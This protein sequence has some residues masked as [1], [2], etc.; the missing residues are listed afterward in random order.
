MPSVQKAKHTA[1][2]GSK[3]RVYLQAPRREW[4]TSLRVIPAWSL[5]WGCFKEENKEAGINHCP[6]TFLHFLIMVLGRLWWLMAQGLLA[7][8]ALQ[9]PDLVC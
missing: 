9:K 3:I 2:V 8:H 1:D 7:H 6:V 4:D 5:I